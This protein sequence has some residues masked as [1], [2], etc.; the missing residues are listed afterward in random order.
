MSYY[1]EWKCGA[2]TDQEYSEACR[3]E[4][5]EDAYYLDRLTPEE[6]DGDCDTCQHQGPDGGCTLCGCDYKRAED[7]E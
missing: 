6:N 4:A 3:R 5:A 1:S 7:D 2:I